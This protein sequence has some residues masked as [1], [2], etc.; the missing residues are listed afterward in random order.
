MS[1][2]V[3]MMSDK[4]RGVIYTGVTSD[5]QG[6]A[7]EHRNATQKGFTQKYKAKNLVWFETHPN[8]VAAIKREKSLKRYLREWKIRL[9]EELNPTWIDLYERVGEIENVY[10]PHPNTRLW[11]DY[12]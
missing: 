7:W 5:L 9:V 1:G 6:R 12:N 8:I 11:E 10:R 4:P 2:F 3:Y